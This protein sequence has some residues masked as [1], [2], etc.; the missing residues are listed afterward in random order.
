MV[1][2]QTTVLRNWAACV[3]VLFLGGGVG[4]G[5]CG[6]GDNARSA[7]EGGSASNL[8]AS[9]EGLTG[10]DD[11]AVNADGDTAANAGRALKTSTMVDRVASS[12][13][14]GLPVGTAPRTVEVW[15]RTT[16]TTGE[17][18]AV[19]YGR[20]LQSQGIYV[21]FLGG[22]AVVT[23]VGQHFTGTSNVADG[24]WHHLACVF[25]NGTY[26]LF[27][28][29][30]AEATAAMPTNTSATGE[31]VVGSTVTGQNKPATGTFDEVRIWSVARSEADLRATMRTRLT[32]NEPGLV[33]Y[34]DM[35]V[36]DLGPGVRVPNLATATGSALDGTTA[37]TRATIS[38][39]A[40]P[41]FVESTAFT[42]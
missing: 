13:I 19:T 22:R 3:A 7:A 18:Y 15:V 11:G 40:T 38:T 37:G 12:N 10:G 35:D 30:T 28:D 1:G 33:L 26:R 25:S 41:A 9:G 6:D 39:G 8:A 2:E 23:Q 4:A 29:G 34:Y 14:A 17:Q 24:R 20:E 31:L 42:P 21:G 32:G 27:V 36:T 5:G 16:Q